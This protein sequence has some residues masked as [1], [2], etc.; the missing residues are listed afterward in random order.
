MIKSYR[1]KPVVIQAVLWDGSNSALHDIA[2]LKAA[3]K[4]TLNAGTRELKIETLEGTMTTSAGDYLIKGVQGEIY[5]CKPDIFAD[6]YEEVTDA[7]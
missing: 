7:D 6:T 4:F 1:K 3:C 5:P 2:E